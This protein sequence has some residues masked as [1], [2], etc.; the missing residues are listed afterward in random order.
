MITRLGRMK[1]TE[2]MAPAD[3]Q[4]VC[5]ILF[6]RMLEPENRP[7]KAI[8]ITAAGIE[9]AMVSPT[10]SPRYI[11]AAVK[12]KVSATPRRDAAPGQFFACRIM[13]IA[14]RA[15]NAGATL[16]SLR[17]AT[18]FRAIPQSVPAGHRA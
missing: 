6:S 2:A 10:F 7:R 11:L 3:E 12:R 14:L 8:E 9:V 17:T 16:P 18:P 13:R 5:T 1:M 15:R 4:T